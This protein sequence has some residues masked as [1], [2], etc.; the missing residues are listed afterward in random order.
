MALHGPG[1]LGVSLPH[2]HGATR[3]PEYQSRGLHIDAGDHLHACFDLDGTALAFLP[4][5]HRAI[6]PSRHQMPGRFDQRRY[7]PHMGLQ[8]TL[9]Q[10]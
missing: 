6:A 10:P 4:E 8:C 3:G 1:L 9:H 5:F 7:T 2:Q